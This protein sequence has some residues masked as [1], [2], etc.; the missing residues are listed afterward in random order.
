MRLG[1]VGWGRGGRRGWR[2]GEGWLGGRGGDGV[3][4]V[5][6][7]FVG[8]VLKADSGGLGSIVA[9]VVVS[10]ARRGGRTVGGRWVRWEGGWR[11]SRRRGEM[12]DMMRYGCVSRRKEGRM[13][14]VLD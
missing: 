12:M 4:W 8:M 7:S 10:R 6:V 14:T 11:S 3:V 1:V 13:T 5:G 9:V 2:W